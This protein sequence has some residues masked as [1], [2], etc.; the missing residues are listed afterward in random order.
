M[1]EISKSLDRKNWDQT[2]KKETTATIMMIKKS[3]FWK[4]PLQMANYQLTEGVCLLWVFYR[5]ERGVGC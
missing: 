4:Q 1:M 5:G 2:F 3:F